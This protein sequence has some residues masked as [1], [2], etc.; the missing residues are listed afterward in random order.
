MEGREEALVRIW[1][2]VEEKEKKGKQEN[3]DNLYL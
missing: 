1:I 2:R 3:L